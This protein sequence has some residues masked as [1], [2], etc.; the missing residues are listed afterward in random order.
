[1][2]CNSGIDASIANGSR[3]TWCDSSGNWNITYPTQGPSAVRPHGPSAIVGQS[4][5]YDPN[6][7][8]RSYTLLGQTRTFTYD[9]D[10]RPTQIAITGG[11]TTDFA[12]GPDGERVKK[13][14]AGG[15]DESWYLGAD[16][17]LVISSAASSGEWTQFVHPAV[18]RSGTTLSWLSKDHLGS[19]R[20]VT[21]GSGGLPAGN[22][23]AYLPFGKPLATPPVSKSYI[24]ERYDGE[25]GLQYLHNRY[26]DSALGR[27]LSPD[28][29]DPAMSGVDINRYAYALNDPINGRDPYGHFVNN[30]KNDNQTS[31]PGPGCCSGGGNISGGNSTGGG[32]SYEQL[33]ARNAREHGTTGT[34]VG[35]SG[36]SDTSGGDGGGSFRYGNVVIEPALELSIYV[37]GYPPWDYEYKDEAG[38]YHWVGQPYPSS[39][40]GGYA[41]GDRGDS[42]GIGPDSGWVT[43]AATRTPFAY[44]Q[45]NVPPEIANSCARDCVDSWGDA[46]GISTGLVS[47]GLPSVPKPGGI[48][49][50]WVSGPITSPLSSGLRSMTGNARIPGEIGKITKSIAGTTSVG[51]ILA[52]T[53]KTLGLG[54]MLLSTTAIA[55]CANLCM[56]DNM[57]YQGLLPEPRR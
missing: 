35:C 23:I 11:I 17:E 49:G 45:I 32:N 39:P 4:V 9:G 6:G 18:K 36:S 8:T 52:K 54:G 31:G 25:T 38:G 10:N 27:F 26:Y 15:T 14:I 56:E 12:Y 41:G 1:M 28:T 2:V 16:L 30:S 46:Y 20:A 37:H 33:M 53:L 22:R 19:N 21:N 57:Q 55:H 24:N 44:G 40:G 43:D 47:S 7:N 29:W 50:G 5:T 34:C 48:A 13:K 51:G 42:G 3:K